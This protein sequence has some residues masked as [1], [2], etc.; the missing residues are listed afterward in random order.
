MSERKIYAYKDVV[1]ELLFIYFWEH[2]YMKVIFF[3][4]W[5]MK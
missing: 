5:N 2:L 3:H 4:S 1:L